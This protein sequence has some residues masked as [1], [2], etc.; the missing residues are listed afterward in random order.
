MYE[1]MQKPVASNK[2][3]ISHACNILIHSSVV[4]FDLKNIPLLFLVLFIL[5]S[6]VAESNNRL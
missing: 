5:I 3:A 2:S 1:C 6:L 4:L